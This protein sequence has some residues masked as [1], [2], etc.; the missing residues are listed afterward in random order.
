MSVTSLFGM[1][2]TRQI[3]S[4]KLKNRSQDVTR[5]TVQKSIVLLTS[6]PHAFGQLRERLA[7]AT[8][9]WFAQADFSDIQI[10]K[11]FQDSLEPTQPLLELR[12]DQSFGLSLREIIHDFRHQTL[13]LLKCLL[14]QRKMLFFGSRCE[15][16][17]LLQFSLVSLIPGL[18][19]NLQ[20][21]SD[22]AMDT[23]AQTVQPA[24]SLRTTDRSSM[25][26]YVGLPLQIFGKGS[27]FSP[28]AP[29]QHLDMLAAYD[30]KSYVVG[31]TNSL[32]LQHKDEYADILVNLDDDNSVTISSPSLR[33]AL[34]LSAADRRWID[35]L[36][37][38]MHDT[39]DP[40][41]PSRPNNHRYEAS[42]EHLRH[43]F[44]E[45][46][47]ALLSS[48][49]Y[50][51]HQER[52]P[53]MSQGSVTTSGESDDTALTNEADPTT[54]FNPDFMSAWIE[55]SNYKLF[56]RLT[57][58][59]NIF[60][61]VVPSHPTAGGLKIEDIQ[62]RVAQKMV[63]LQLDERLRETREIL[64]Q[65][66]ASGK[67]QVNRFWADVEARRQ[68]SQQARKS[69]SRS[70][71]RSG[72]NGEVRSPKS[73]SVPE[74]IDPGSLAQPSQLDGTALATGANWASALR[75]R[76]SK[77]QKPDMTQVQTSAK[78]NAIKAQAYL[79]SW[80]SWAKEGVRDW[81][82]ARKTPEKGPKPSGLRGGAEDE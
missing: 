14:L 47:L 33:T 55:T 80:S 54:D 7:A 42:E 21:C 16:V 72:M 59:A 26:A 35:E 27:F 31:S 11:D 15:R 37:L 58:D 12:F 69:R 39:W 68:K 57:K 66:L 5:S 23:Y 82:E 9:A 50:K 19:Q 81:Q 62:R 52:R 75:E 76:A 60:D 64:N 48:V 13:V 51:D 74:E 34:V 32:L 22:P 77:V 78:E 40:D 3:E 1:S 29:L 49:S 36:T 10:L 20:D 53:Q 65:G 18:I 79:S 56:N 28:Y 8:N 30:T 43:K 38:L 70:K 44:E 24:T 45:Y 17:C 41:N 73:D 6:E 2:C 61:I 46:I 4:K 71:S 25:L 67:E 63:D